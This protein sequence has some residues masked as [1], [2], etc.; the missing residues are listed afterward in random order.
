MVVSD[1]VLLDADLDDTDRARL[2]AFLADPLLQTGD[3]GRPAARRPTPTRSPCTPASPT[4]PPTRVVARRRPARHR[5]RA[6]PPVPGASSCRPAL[7]ADAVDILLRRVARQPGD[8]A[9]GAVDRSSPGSHPGIDRTSAAE[10]V[11]VRDLDAAGLGAPRTRRGRWRSIPPSWWRSRSTS[12][13]R[14]ATRPTSS[15]RRSPRRGASTART[16]RSGPGSR[17]T[18]ASELVPLMRQLRD[19]TDAI[20]APFVRSAFVGN[21]GIV[22]FVDGDDARPQ[23]RDAQPPVGRRAVRW[24]QHR[25]RR[26]DPRRDGRRPPTARRHRRALLRPARR[27]RSPSVPDRRAAPA[28]H[29]RG[30]HRRRRRLRQQDRA[31]DDRRRRALRPRRSPPTRS[32]SAAASASPPTEP[33]PTGPFAGDRVRRARR[34]HRSRRDPRRDVLQRCRWTPRTGEVAGASVQIGDPITEKLLIDVLADV[35]DLWTAITDCGAGGLSSA[36][37]E[38][39]EHLGAD[40][41]LDRGAAQVPGPR[42]VGDLAV[43]GPGA[44]GRGR[45]AGE[46]RRA[47]QAALR[48]PRRRAHRRRRRSP[49]TAAGGA[50]RRRASWSTCATAFLHDGRPQRATDRRRARARSRQPGRP[51]RST[52]RRRRC[53]PCSLTATSPRRRPSIHRYDHEIG[54][55][56]VVRPLIGEGDRRARRRRRARRPPTTTTASPSASASTRGTG[57]TTPRRWRHVVVDE[58]IRNVVAVGADPDHVALLDN[59]SWGD[60]LDAATLGELVAAVA[61]CCRRRDRLR[62]PVRVRQGLAEQRLRRRRRAAPRRAADARDHGDRPRAR[63]RG[64]R[65]RRAAS[66]RQRA[67]AARPH[68]ASSSPAATSTWCGASHRRPSPAA[69]ATPQPDPDAPAR[70]RRLH[71]AIR[72]GLVASCHDVSEGGLAV[73]AGRA[74]HRR[75]SRRQRSTRTA[76]PTSPPACSP[77]AA[78]ASSSRSRPTTSPPSAELG[79]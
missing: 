59:F 9:V 65:H 3:V 25:R 56:T 48:P 54:G 26:R 60:P 23:G 37:G 50:P 28:A 39:A 7:P 61:G 17:S 1:V 49:A 31:A 44:H 79:R 78:D 43:R 21:A 13:P 45:G 36:V 75:A 57:C 18:T 20:A 42:A 55:A 40:V 8:R 11:P 72:A 14:A 6:P 15:S 16:R 46:S 52:I 69:G 41:E 62:R 68:R 5:R 74:V 29:P 77:R 32:C 70:Y 24:R 10:S 51:P 64:V 53:W 47:S 58:A 30:R 38:M 33:P 63:R 19:A 76:M 12:A 73:A 35:G 66:A 67:P 27:R 34:A 2:G 71:A 4:A 22:S